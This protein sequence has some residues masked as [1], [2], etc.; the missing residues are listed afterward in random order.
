MTRP[1]CPNCLRPKAQLFDRYDAERL[2]W[3][4]RSDYGSH[5]CR[6]AERARLTAEIRDL[7]AGFAA[8]WAEVDALQRDAAAAWGPLLAISGALNFCGSPDELAAAVTRLTRERDEAMNDADMQRQAVTYETAAANTLR[9]ERDEAQAAGAAMRE[10]LELMDVNGDR[11]SIHAPED[12]ATM[13]LCDRFGYGAVMDSAARQWRAMGGIMEVGAF[14]TGPCIGTVKRALASDAG[15]A[16]LDRLEK[17]ERER[18]ANAARAASIARDGDAMLAAERARAAKAE[19][20]L[21]RE[22]ERADRLRD[23]LA[24]TVK[25]LRPFVMNFSTG[26]TELDAAEAALGKDPTHE[27]G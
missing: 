1:E 13:A 14:L 3:A 10:A 25:A 2:C 24:C 7:R 5:L 11:Q 20:D 4:D 27:P 16:L 26:H 19:A 18:D 21:Q 23:A 22:R 15:R 17:A 8:C 6:L 9:R 12:P